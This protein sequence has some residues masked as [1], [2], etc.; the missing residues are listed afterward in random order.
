LRQ[1]IEHQQCKIEILNLQKCIGAD[2]IGD[3]EKVC[4]YIDYKK[5]VADRVPVPEDFDNDL[6]PRRLEVKVEKEIWS[7]PTMKVGRAKK[8]KC[9]TL[10]NAF[11][12]Y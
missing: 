4:D 3:Q 9:S 1:G 10:Q 12:Y 11:L 8:D 7:C 6:D 2:E 5:V